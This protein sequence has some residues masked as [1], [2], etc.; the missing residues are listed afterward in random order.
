MTEE[1]V[2]AEDDDGSGA[3]V[4]ACA[5]ELCNAYS[6]R[7]SRKEEQKLLMLAGLEQLGQLGP[8]EREAA[9]GGGGKAVV[10][11]TAMLVPVIAIRAV[12]T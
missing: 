9:G 11:A 5:G 2:C 8:E 7:A 12:M 1:P 4:C 6:S 10:G 3:R